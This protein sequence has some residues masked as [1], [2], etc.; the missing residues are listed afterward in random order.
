LL[1]NIA[2]AVAAAVVD[3]DDLAFDAIGKFDGT[4]PPQNLRERVALVEDGNDHRDLA[5][6]RRG[7]GLAPRGSCRGCAPDL[8][9]SPRAVPNR[10]AF[11]LY[12]Y[13]G[14]GASGRRPAAVRTRC[15]RKTP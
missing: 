2:G 14:G 6:V 5:K 11:V 9:A 10:A 13:L 7:H 8:R 3:H 12:R 1:E 15:L 4:H